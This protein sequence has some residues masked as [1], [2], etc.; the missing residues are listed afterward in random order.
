M[1][2]SKKGIIVIAVAIYYGVEYYIEYTKV[3]IPSFVNYLQINPIF[4]KL[5]QLLERRLYRFSNFLARNFKLGTTYGNMRG[6]LEIVM[7]TKGE[8]DIDASIKRH[9]TTINKVNATIYS[10]THSEEKFRPVIIYYHGGGYVI[11]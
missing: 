6:L 10:S 7:Q 2:L 1:F 8:K 5:N 4:Y 9:R 11:I 3:P